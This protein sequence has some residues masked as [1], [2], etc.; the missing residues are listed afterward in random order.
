LQ[1]GDTVLTLGTGGVSIFALQ[2]AVAAGARVL[3]TSSSDTKLERARELGAWQAI[4]YVTTPDWEKEVFRLT[5]NQGVDHVVELGGPG[6]LGK[7]IMSV[8]AGGQIA[9]IGVLTGFDPPKDSIF[10][11]MARNAR[12]EGIYAGARNDLE[13]LG[14]FMSQKQIRPV[15]DRV[16]AFAEATDAFEHLASGRHFGKVVIAQDA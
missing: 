13:A 9:L 6:T 8:A 7:S 11:L 1:A 3:I 5:E 14:E 16:F 12:I 15:I 10:P 2:L 4:N